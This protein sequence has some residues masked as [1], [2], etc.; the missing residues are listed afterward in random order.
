VGIL[1]VETKLI[2]AAIHEPE[3]GVVLEE[4]SAVKPRGSLNTDGEGKLRFL[5]K[6]K[7]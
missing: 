2:M 7:G 4:T 3:T 6:K 1:E 5:E